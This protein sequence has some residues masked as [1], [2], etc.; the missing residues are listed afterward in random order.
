MIIPAIVADNKEAKVPPITTAT[1]TCKLGKLLLARK[2]A[3]KAVIT[4]SKSI[5]L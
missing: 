5:C 1:K 3:D 4:K 2:I